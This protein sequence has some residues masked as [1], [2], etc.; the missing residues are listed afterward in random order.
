MAGLVPAIPVL[1]DA[2][3]KDIGIIHANASRN[4]LRSLDLGRR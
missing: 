1:F 4:P 3:T 2:V